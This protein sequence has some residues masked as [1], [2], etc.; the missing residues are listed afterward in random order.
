MD[1]SGVYCGE[2]LDRLVAFDHGAGRPLPVLPN[3]SGL[4]TARLSPNRCLAG[5]P[6]PSCQAK[7]SRSTRSE[8]ARRKEKTFRKGMLF[9]VDSPGL[10]GVRRLVGHM[11][12]LA[13][14]TIMQ[15]ATPILQPRK[16]DNAETKVPRK[17]GKTNRSYP[18]QQPA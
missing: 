16:A 2:F 17:M 4:G 3:W 13:S 14:R 7:L 9:S 15:S 6:C 10:I 8:D 1:S 18:Y 11:A 12:N 5:L